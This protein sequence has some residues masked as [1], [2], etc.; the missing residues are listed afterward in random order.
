MGMKIIWTVAI[1]YLATELNIF[2]QS[3]ICLTTHWNN[4]A[5]YNPAFIARTD[6][7]YLFANARHQWFGVEGN[8]QTINIQA[9]GYFHDIRSAI[10]L[11]LAGD[12]IGLTRSFN[13]MVHYAYRIA[14]NDNW[15]LALG[16]SAGMF[17]RSTDGSRYEAE[18][19]TDP[20]LTY[21]KQQV[22]YPDAN[23]GL[24]FQN[25]HFI[26]GASSTHL[27]SIR[28][29]D[30][31]FLNANHRYAY[32]IYKNNNI[33]WLFY[34]LGVMVVNRDNFTVAEGNIFLRFKHPTGLMKGPR[35]IF[36]L[37]ISY[38]SSR[39]VAFML[40]IM[41]TPDLRV[42]YAYDQ[43]LI[44][45]YYTNS[46]HEIM[47]EYRIFCRASSTKIRCGKDLFWYH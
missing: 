9:S 42:G 17:I 12:E 11:S 26:I 15:S 40:G 36:D 23:L 8:P 28:S 39:Q 44:Q 13:P 7:I 3:D 41:L 31:V 47:L 5:S 20:S 10:G 14:K 2:A 35:D 18:T 24:E 16:L 29:S 46:T 34:K 38:R 43:S 27:L 30:T 32:A 1:L 33:N 19:I 45:G 6:Y 25:T 22:T 37:G 21:E 4:R